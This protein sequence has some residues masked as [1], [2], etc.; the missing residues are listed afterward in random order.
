MVSQFEDLQAAYLSLRRGMPHSNGATPAANGAASD[1]APAVGGEN[2]AAPGSAPRNG[3]S[4]NGAAGGPGGAQGGELV[5]KGDRRLGAV[6]SSSGF[7]EFS[8]MLSVFTHC[9]KL[10]VRG[11]SLPACRALRLKSA[12]LHPVSAP[13]AT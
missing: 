8:R 1:A 10:K 6:L 2:G 11:L 12:E 4:S 3:E 7:A 5:C 13:E 9:S